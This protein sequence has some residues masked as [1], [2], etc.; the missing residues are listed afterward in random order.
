M[1]RQ[2]GHLAD[3]GSVSVRGSV[4]PVKRR[5]AVCR[6]AAATDCSERLSPH[7]R[8]GA[9]TKAG[10]ARAG[11]RG[12]AQAGEAS[13]RM[14]AGH[15]ADPQHRSATDG[16]FKCDTKS[17]SFSARGAASRS[18]RFASI[19]IAICCPIPR[20]LKSG[21]LSTSCHARAICVT[22]QCQGP[23]R[24]S[25]TMRRRHCRRPPRRRVQRWRKP[26]RPGPGTA[27]SARAP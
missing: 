17:G 26:G 27:D 8:S 5:F 6:F 9:D 2:D 20:P 1:R 18:S 10:P 3:R 13:Q 7:S 12:Q 23:D 16:H 4:A 19:L 21:D 11:G 22:A 14:T 24:A 25:Q 15:R